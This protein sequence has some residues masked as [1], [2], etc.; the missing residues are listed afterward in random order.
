MSTPA[1][2]PILHLS[3]SDWPESQRMDVWHEVYG[4]QM[5][6]LEITPANDQP[7]YCEL[8]LR[9]LPGLGLAWGASSAFRVG[10]T[11]ELLTATAV[12]AT[13]SAPRPSRCVGRRST[14]GARTG[15]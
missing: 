11:R 3:S 12:S 4:R 8:K 14:A 7:F 1:D 10:R 2:A 5:M 9:C 13:V 15:R 6:R